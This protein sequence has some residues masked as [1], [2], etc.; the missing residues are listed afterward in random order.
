MILRETIGVP[1]PNLAQWLN[2][3]VSLFP[4]EA[5]D[6]ILQSIV[7][8][9]QHRPHTPETLPAIIASDPLFPTIQKEAGAKEIRRAPKS[10]KSES[11]GAGASTTRGRQPVRI[12]PNSPVARTTAPPA[13]ALR[14]EDDCTTLTTEHSHQRPFTLFSET[15]PLFVKLMKNLLRGLHETTNSRVISLQAGVLR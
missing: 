2:Y 15:D 12:D 10:E 6:S 3:S 7:D 11:E 9:M 13:H 8:F 5:Q 14:Q 4:V 1:F